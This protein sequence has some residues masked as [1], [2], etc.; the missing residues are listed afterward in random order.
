MYL[1]QLNLIQDLET[2]RVRAFDMGVK[3]LY[4]T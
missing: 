4:K 3:S 2:L 1:S